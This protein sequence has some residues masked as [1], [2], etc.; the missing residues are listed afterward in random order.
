MHIELLYDVYSELPR[1]FA[2]ENVVILTLPKQMELS[3][4]RIAAPI[5]HIVLFKYLSTALNLT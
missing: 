2:E 1:K 3:I 5:S 4:F